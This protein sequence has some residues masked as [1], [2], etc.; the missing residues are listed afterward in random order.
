[1]N[2]VNCNCG[3][4]IDVDFPDTYNSATCP[5]LILEILEGTF[6]SV[7]CP[8]CKTVIKPELPVRIIDESNKINI[9]F[10]PE[11]ER[12]QFLTEKLNLPSTDR[13]TF[14]YLE[15]AEKVLSFTKGLDDQVVEIIKYFYL[16]KAGAGSDL[17]I[18][19]VDADHD[20]L[21]FHI[22][23]LKEQE[24]GIAN[25]GYEFYQR[26]EE[27]LQNIVKNEGLHE[28]LIPP[29]VSIKKVY[30]GEE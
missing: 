2:T 10:R 6:M 12:I 30:L 4:K 29:Y 11:E 25:I 20:N 15:L 3:N 7:Q 18:H 16:K 14:G 21:Q 27:D 19:L 13:V 1:M 5:N 23:G 17:T 28:V 9:L 22:H 26:I 24:I 8:S